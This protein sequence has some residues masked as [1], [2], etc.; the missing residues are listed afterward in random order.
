MS[1]LDRMFKGKRLANL[2]T[3]SEFS[4]AVE[5]LEAELRTIV[6]ERDSIEARK[7]QAL[8]GG[9]GDIKEIRKQAAELDERV[10]IVSAALNGSRKRLA[11]AQEAERQS[12][13]EARMQE[14]QKLKAEQVRLVI[15]YDRYASG[16]VTALTRLRELSGLLANENNYAKAEGRKDLVIGDTFADIRRKLLQTYEADKAERGIPS[17]AFE[18]SGQQVVDLGRDERIVLPDYWPHRSSLKCLDGRGIYGLAAEIGD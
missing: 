14:A 10:E 16:I 4:D 1:F 9:D 12:V 2:R 18:V 13:V 17:N 5:R 3:A 6:T 8:F 11:E 15:E 7:E